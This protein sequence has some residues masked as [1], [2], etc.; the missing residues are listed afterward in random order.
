M[1]RWSFISIFPTRI[2]T[3]HIILIW[4]TAFEHHSTANS[5]LKLLHKL[6]ICNISRSYTRSLLSPL[7]LFLLQYAKQFPS[8]NALPLYLP[9]SVSSKSELGFER[10][11]HVKPWGEFS[12]ACSLK[13]EMLVQAVRFQQPCCK[14]YVTVEDT[15]DVKQFSLENACESIK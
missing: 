9:L 6:F 14:L 8:R 1:F 5:F 7:L 3:L 12:G 11:F 2:P 4:K 10:I 13:E 15:G